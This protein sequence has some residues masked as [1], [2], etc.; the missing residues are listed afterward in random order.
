MHFLLS[1][2]IVF[3]ASS[4]VHM[5]LPWHKSDYHKMP[6]EDKFIDAVSPLAIP[7]GDYF[8]PRG[9]GMA[10]MK[11]PEFAAK[12][13]KGPVV[14]LTVM[15]NEMMGMGRSLT[16]WFLYSVVIGFF[17]AY[18]A[19][20]T[21]APGVHYLKGFQIV[22]ATAFMGYTVALWQ[23]SIWFRRAWSTTIKATIDGLLY[24]ILTSGPFL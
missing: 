10:D 5:A 23:L 20:R 7:P 21:L 12:L 18:I 15:P 13:K 3:V 22:G 2:V 6:N 19:S 24:P 4:I 8:V 14:V 9:R 11:S 16:L 17:S 1:A